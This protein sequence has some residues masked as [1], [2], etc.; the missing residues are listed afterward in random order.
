MPKKY[1]H[2]KRG[3]TM[4]YSV[5]DL[6]KAVDGIRKASETFPVPK[7]TIADHSETVSVTQGRPP[8]LD[9]A[10]EMKIVNAGKRSAQL[11]IGLSRKQIILRA[12]VLCQRTKIQSSYSK[13]HAGKD[14]WKGVCN[15]HKEL[16][17]RTPEKLASTRSRMMNNE[18]I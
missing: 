13:F 16:E 15:R 18:V 5:S 11:G 6:Q 12:N 1:V 14:W 9:P 3:N 4:R 17:V 8:A 2:T 7:S 10:L